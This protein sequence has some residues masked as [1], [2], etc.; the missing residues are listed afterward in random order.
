MSLTLIRPS[1]FAL[2]SLDFALTWHVPARPRVG[3]CDTAFRMWVGKR[4]SSAMRKRQRTGALHDA[5]A[6]H[7]SFS[8]RVVRPP[9]PALL[10][11]RGGKAGMEKHRT[12]IRRREDAM[13]GRDIERPTSNSGKAAETE[14]AT[15]IPTRNFG[16][17]R[18]SGKPLGREGRL[19]RTLALS[20]RQGPIAFYRLLSAFTAFYRLSIGGG[21]NVI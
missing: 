1:D 16:F 13:A 15:A 21:A 8:V 2:P 4:L 11:G 12:A 20:E 3:S 17:S 7:E 19:T 10:S 9:S 6:R 5:I 18:F 14:M